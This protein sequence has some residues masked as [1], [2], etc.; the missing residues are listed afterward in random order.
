MKL[1][2]RTS[3]LSVLQ[4]LILGTAFLTA[5][6]VGQS[7]GGS[8]T[9]EVDGI[10][11][12]YFEGG[13]G[14]PMV[15][16]HGGHYGMSGGAVG[17]M[18]VFPMLAEHFHV[19]AVDNLGMGLTE[20]PKEDAGYSMQATTQHLYRFMQTLGLENV[21][22]VGHSRGGLPVARIAMDHPELIKT[23]TIFDSNTLAPG[24]PKAST[25]NLRP[26]EP[27]STRES[28]RDDLMASHTTYQKDFITDEYVEALLEGW[29]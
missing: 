2:T 12:R 23:L 9:V 15:L 5:A 24:D 1:S 22:L 18:S 20:N 27:P 7:M 3:A 10:E 17:F 14:E 6:D 4:V 21:H 26:V 29:P 8:K 25:P 11:T 28:I 13:S 19:F 16:V